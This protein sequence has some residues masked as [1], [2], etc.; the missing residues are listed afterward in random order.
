MGSFRIAKRVRDSAARKNERGG[1]TRIPFA[2]T[3][4]TWPNASCVSSVLPQKVALFD[5]GSEARLL[6]PLESSGS[7]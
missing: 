7:S 4:P 3:A 6:I 1:G 2:A 5:I